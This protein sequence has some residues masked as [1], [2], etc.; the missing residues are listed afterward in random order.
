[1]KIN[2]NGGS[3]EQ[4]GLVNDLSRP[5]SKREF[6]RWSGMGAVALTVVGCDRERTRTITEVRPDTIIVEPTPPT[7]AAATLN[8]TNDFGV[9]NYAFAL[10]QLE[11]AFYTQVIA[12]PY[13]GITAAERQVLTDLR[14]HEVIH[15]EFLRAAIPAL[16]GT[17]IPNLTPNFT[18]INFND[19]ISVL[20]AARNF[21]DLGVG[22]Y[23]G[24]GQFLSNPTLLGLAGKI[25]SVEARHASAVRDLITPR[26]RDFAP[27]AFDDALRPQQVIATAAPFIRNSITVTNV[28]AFVVTDMSA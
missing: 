27:R 2:E 3:E 17:L 11:A 22:A 6:L 15:R 28:P 1:M 21:E 5:V 20:T 23:N 8:F 16:G 13:A 14:D 12:T 9:L 4:N 19:R 25:V 7:F 26:S 10:E 18:S 24:S